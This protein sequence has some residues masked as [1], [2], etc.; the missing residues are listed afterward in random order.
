MRR[1]LRFLGVFMIVLIIFTGLSYSNGVG[2]A[3]TTSNIT[4]DGTLDESGNASAQGKKIGD[5]LQQISELQTQLSHEKDIRSQTEKELLE[6]KQQFQELQQELDE[7][8]D[9][10]PNENSRGS[11]FQSLPIFNTFTSDYKVAFLTF[12]DGPSSITPRILDILEEKDVDATFFVVGT[13]IEKYPEYIR[14]AHEEGNSVLPHSFTHQFSIY[15]SIDIFYEDLQMATDAIKNITGQELVPVCRLP[16]GSTNSLSVKYGGKGI[17]AKLTDDL[18]KEGYFYID[19]NVEAGDATG[20]YND[21]DALL[22][23]ILQQTSNKNF[24]V[25]LF[26]DLARNSC[27]ADILPE[28]IDTLKAQGYI[29]KTFNDVSQWDMDKMVRMKIANRQIKR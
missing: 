12:D 3:Y 27:T 16:G 6:K 29:F 18:R 21:K 22:K 15:S 9:H 23:N 28:V 4:N 20:I 25:I 17:M 10:I 19:W 24:A 5:L 7:L 11:W 26:H 2:G 1:E 13:F 8:L 14:R